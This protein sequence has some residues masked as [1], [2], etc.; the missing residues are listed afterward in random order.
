MTS[1]L[2]VSFVLLC[3]LLVVGAVLAALSVRAENVHLTI[4][5]ETIGA[6]RDYWRHRGEKLI[7]A[8]LA[9]AGAIHQPTMEHGG[10]RDSVASAA[11]LITSAMAVREIDSRKKDS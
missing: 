6:E 10:P 7:D 5:V 2:L 3:A 11:A 1:W 4:Q 9:R 8:A